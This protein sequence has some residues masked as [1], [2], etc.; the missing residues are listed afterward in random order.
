MSPAPTTRPLRDLGWAVSIVAMLGMF[1][2]VVEPRPETRQN[3]RQLEA[4]VLLLLEG[5]E[6]PDG[7]SIELPRIEVTDWDGAG[8]ATANCSD[9]RIRVRPGAVSSLPDGALDELLAHELAHLLV[10]AE[11][12]RRAAHDTEWWRMYRRI[13]TIG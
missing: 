12:G 7:V 8:V 5:Y 9:W 13:Y 3:E 2:T 6:H 11:E 1:W 4:R 10:C